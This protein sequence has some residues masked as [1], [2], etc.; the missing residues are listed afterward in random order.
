MKTITKYIF[1]QFISSFITG[2]VVIIF[3][4]ILNNLFQLID[5]LVHRGAGFFRVAQLAF[6]LV[7]TLISITIPVAL[8]FASI[9]TYGRLTEDNEI[10]A[11]W[12]GGLHTYKFIWQ[13]IFLGSVMTLL[14]IWLNFSAV[15]RIQGKFNSL[16]FEMAKSH[17]GTG[18]E[19][20][21]FRKI[22]D[23]RIYINKIDKKTE[24]LSGITIYKLDGEKSPDI[25]RIFARQGNIVFNE[26]KDFIFSL[27]DGTL[28]T[29]RKNDLTG[30]THF[31]FEKYNLVIPVNEN[32]PAATHSLREFTGKE[33]RDEIRKYREESISTRNLDT[34]YF[35]RWAVSVAGISFVLIGLPL[36]IVLHRGGMSAGFGVSVIVI[37]MYYFCLMGCITVASKEIIPARYILWL[38][39]L[40]M[41][42]GG[43]FLIRK[44]IR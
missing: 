9:L 19:E 17:P 7:V 24:I 20:K 28:Q 11:L 33:L 1:R 25:T 35:L 39:N 22:G 16:F 15:P 8:L 14:L 18:F 23:Y 6:Y 12:S 34:E 10:I 27:Q 13:P 43:I 26:Q 42:T 4:L 38:P 40:I 37:T 3:L 5:L 41:I 36:G 44:T 32:V 21:T 30:F 31:K 29:G 2:L